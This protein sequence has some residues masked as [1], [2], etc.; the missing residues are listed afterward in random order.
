MEKWKIKCI[1]EKCKCKK[2]VE[3]LS[4]T[5]DLCIGGDCIEMLQQ[6]SAVLR[7]IPYMKVF[8]RVAPEQKELIL[9]TFKTVGRMTLK[10]GDGSN[11]VGALKQLPKSKINL[12]FL[13]NLVK[14]HFIA[15]REDKRKLRQ[16]LSLIVSDEIEMERV[17]IV[18]SNTFFVQAHVGVAFL[19]ALPLTQN[20]ASSSGTSKEEKTKSGKSQKSKSASDAAGKPITQ[21]EEGSSTSHTFGNRHQAA[22][23]M[24]RQKMKMQIDEMTEAYVL[25]VMHLDGVKLG[26]VQATISG[27][28]TAALF[29]F[30]SHAR[31]LPTLSAARPHPNIFCLYV[32]LSL[33]GQFAIHLLFLMSCVKEAENYMPDECIEPDSDFYRNLVNTVG[34][35]H[36]KHDAP[37]G[38]FCFITSDVFRDL[39]DCFKLLPLP[40]G[41]RDKLVIWASLMFLSC[42][43]WE[44][45]L[46]WAFPGRVPDWKKRQ[47]VAAANLDKKHV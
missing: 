25:S 18:T 2:E 44:K 4:E 19:N 1:D 16:D 6:T 47:R 34:F 21:N 42:Y 45:V 32:F 11:D 38:H 15:R 33:M 31:P 46:M 40:R 10:C 13:P 29:L 37:G 28:F 7:V 22:V 5:H 39:N 36:G 14:Y 23:A 9:T 35:I 3:A 24:Q 41:L 12:L 43:S 30:I 20:K 26:D 8:A 27:I 17:N